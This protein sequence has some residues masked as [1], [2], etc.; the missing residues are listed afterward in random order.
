MVLHV[1]PT[2]NMLNTVQ[3]Q[4]L[5]LV[6]GA[7][8]TSPAASIQVEANES[9]LDLRREKL[10]MQY[11][12]KL[13]SNKQN[14]MY[15]VV[16]HAKF[17]PL[18]EKKPS[19]TPTFGIRILPI[20]KSIN[21]NMTHVH[22]NSI[23]PIPPWQLKQ[24]QII[25]DLCEYKKSSSNTDWFL[26]SFNNVKTRHADYVHIYTDG[27]KEREKTGAAIVVQDH[28]IQNRLYDKSSVF[29]AEMKAI[30][31]AFQYIAQSSLLKFLI[32]SDSLSL[33]QAL[34]NSKTE[35]P[36]I[37]LAIEEYT[38]LV[39][40]NKTV[41]FCWV[42]SHIGIEGNEKADNAAKLA[43]G[44]EITDFK[45]PHSDFKIYIT[46][47]THNKWQ[48]SWNLLTTNKLHEIRPLLDVLQISK[49]H[50]RKDEVVLCRARIGHTHLTH[51]YL[52]KNEPRPE[53]S[54]CQQPLTVRHCLF[55]CQKYLSHRPLFP[56]HSANE[57]LA[58]YPN[59]I[60][61][62]LKETGIYNLF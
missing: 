9:P 34:D 47:H 2:K 17:K 57:L 37:R 22:Q 60:I 20:L 48:N 54:I 44:L 10:S 62:F 31:L 61:K 8:R 41:I 30:F 52:L 49:L 33:L 28:I 12:L 38:H 15:S 45:I 26:S 1:H 16:F 21:V 42:P 4:A 29:S 59:I 27:S 32:F 43:L 6:L 19:A 36:L 46:Q 50:T 39:D 14:P 55:E 5:R 58:K 23:S 56:M 24:P 53:C 35:N 11:A 25:L 18:F 51:A 13:S 40:A 7:F 3:N